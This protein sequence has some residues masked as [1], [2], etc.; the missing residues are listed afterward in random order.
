[1]Y[2]VTAYRWGWLN[3]HQY[4]VY[5]GPD[6]TKAVALAE[7]ECNDRGGK[8]GCA[9]YEWN[10]DGTDYKRIAYFGAIMEQ[11]D[12]PFHNWCINYFESMGHTLDNY[13]DGKVYVSTGEGTLRLE[14]I[15]PPPQRILD[16]IQR[17]KRLCEAMTKA[18]NERS[19]NSASDHSP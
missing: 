19:A 15:E 2:L 8:Y 6:R 7:N 10:A 5:C 16:E 3:G 14:D 11:E 1:M 18:Q 9:V 12:A 17:H 4:Q 13:A